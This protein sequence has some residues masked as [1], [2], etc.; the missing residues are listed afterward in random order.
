[1][2]ESSVI[3]GFSFHSDI[4]TLKKHLKHLTFYQNIAA[5]IDLQTYFGRVFDVSGMV[6]LAKVAE[7]VIGKQVCKYNQMSQWEQR[8]LRLAQQHYAALD[9]YILVDL[10]KRLAELG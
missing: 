6:G 2:N 1:M 8:P 4:A 5:F 3:I 9:A 10:I 7:K